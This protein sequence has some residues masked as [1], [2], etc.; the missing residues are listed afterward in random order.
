MTPAGQRWTREKPTVEGWY[1]LVEDGWGGPE[2]V[3]VKS[4]NLLLRVYFTSG[5]REDVGTVNAEWYGPIQRP[6]T[7]NEATNEH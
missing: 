7:P 4:A 3:L 5:R 6:L 2:V 1:W